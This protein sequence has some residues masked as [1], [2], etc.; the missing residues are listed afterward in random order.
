MK[1]CEIRN[2]RELVVKDKENFLFDK[3]VSITF[4]VSPMMSFALRVLRK[5]DE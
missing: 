1:L 3:I 5:E 4:Q 2:C